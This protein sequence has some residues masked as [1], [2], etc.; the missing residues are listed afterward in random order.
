[1]SVYHTAHA[2]HVRKKKDKKKTGGRTVLEQAAMSEQ[3]PGL[4]SGFR[5]QSLQSLIKVPKTDTAGTGMWHRSGY[6]EELSYGSLSVSLSLSQYKL[7]SLTRDT[8]PLTADFVTL[9][10]YHL[11][12]W[13]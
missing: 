7:G 12:G 2:A 5:L 4:G 8:I 6:L 10:H 1:M 9:S 13:R 11:G 3:G